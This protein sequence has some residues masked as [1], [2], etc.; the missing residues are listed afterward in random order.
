MKAIH[1]QQRLQ[2]GIDLGEQFRLG[3]MAILQRLLAVLHP[4]RA[5]RLAGAAQEVAIQST[6]ETC[7]G[8]NPSTALAT[9]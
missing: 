5:V 1:S 2:R 8:A 9:R 3:F 6:T 7:S 4:V